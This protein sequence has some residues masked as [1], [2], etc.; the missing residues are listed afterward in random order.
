M[1]TLPVPTLEVVESHGSL[2]QSRL[3]R[4]GWKSGSDQI[5]KKLLTSELSVQP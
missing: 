2:P 1:N 5:G 4:E 3:G